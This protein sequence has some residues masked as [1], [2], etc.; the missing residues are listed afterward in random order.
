MQPAHTVF[1]Y[2][3][4]NRVTSMQRATAASSSG[5]TGPTWRYDY[6]AASPSEAGTTTVTDPDGDATLYWHNAD[7]EVT[8]VKD[9]LEHYR[10]A[11]FTNH[12]TQTTTDAM[13]TGTDGTGGNVTTYGWD[14]R[15][16]LVKTQ[17]PMGATAQV[18]A[19]QT[20][21][22]TD[23]PN[24]FTSADGRK[25]SFSYDTNGNTLS[26]TTSG[27]A[28]GQRTYTYNKATPSCGG[29]EGQRCTATV[30]I[31]DTRS[32]KTSFTYDANGNL[33]KAAA[34][35]SPTTTP[36]SSPP[37]P[38]PQPRGPMTRPATRRPAAVPPRQHGRTRPGP[39][40]ASWPASRWAART[41][42]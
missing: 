13:G 41:T 10:H 42:T 34:R 1:T 17:L 26:V 25:D 32:S 30:K 22:G 9:P 7:G 19:Y 40:T 6:S 5:H 38:A 27:M 23:L 35:S 20:I 18:T 2:D 12:L 16:N 4:H 24:D 37:R 14:S 8:K 21:A 28:G 11:S 31:S 29:F 36:S 15:N 39:T 33:T 3:S